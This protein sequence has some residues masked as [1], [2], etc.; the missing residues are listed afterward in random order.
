MFDIFA[1]F[2]G[3]SWSWERQ[4]TSSGVQRSASHSEYPAPYPPVSSVPR[5]SSSSS[6]AVTPPHSAAS[7]R[8]SSGGSSSSSIF[9]SSFS[10]L[11]QY[12]FPRPTDTVLASSSQENHRVSA[13]QAP[14]LEAAPATQLSSAFSS[15][16]SEDAST[17]APS[18][19][20]VVAHSRHP[21]H[22]AMGWL[23]FDDDEGE[24]H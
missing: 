21:S 5:A 14:R 23:D 7:H 1:G 11:S 18:A 8:N 16:S 10:E 17:S 2:T 9:N 15:S 6:P 22:R 4:S 19:Q 24:L 12:F 3:R 13:S 20:E